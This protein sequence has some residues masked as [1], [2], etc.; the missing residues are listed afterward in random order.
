MELISFL[1]ESYTSDKNTALRY[2][3]FLTLPNFQQRHELFQGP[4]VI[5]W[6]NA[7]GLMNATNVVISEVQR[8]DTTGDYQF[9]LLKA[10]VRRPM[11][12]LPHYRFQTRPDCYY[13]AGTHDSRRHS[14]SA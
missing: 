4:N 12:K 10:F 7:Q 11:H 3:F 6:S 14:L 8:D 2:L 13:G 5:G 9:V 1:S